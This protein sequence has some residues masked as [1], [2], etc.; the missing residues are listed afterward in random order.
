ME[1]K[2]IKI[3]VVVW[4]GPAAFKTWKGEDFIILTEQDMNRAENNFFCSS[5]LASDLKF[6]G[7][8]KK[9]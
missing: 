2:I 7:F 9:L 4:F 6:T 5:K 1:E 8:K 3:K